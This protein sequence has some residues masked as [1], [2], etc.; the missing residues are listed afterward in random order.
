MRKVGAEAKLAAKLQKNA[1]TT[2]EKAVATAAAAV[3]ASDKVP[4]VA[5]SKHAGTLCR[6]DLPTT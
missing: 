6:Q 5:T 4:V 3:K 2:N 1:E